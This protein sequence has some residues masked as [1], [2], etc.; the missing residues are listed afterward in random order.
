VEGHKAEQ[1]L[2]GQYE[3]CG[4]QFLVVLWTQLQ[5]DLSRLDSGFRLLATKQK[6]RKFPLLIP[7]A[8]SFLE[9]TDV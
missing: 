9:A 4:T 3:V 8:L 5:T 7:Q 2:L 1:S 6:A